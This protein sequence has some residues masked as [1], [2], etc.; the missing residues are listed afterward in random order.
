MCQGLLELMSDRMSSGADIF[1]FGVDFESGW[2]KQDASG[3]LVRYGHET[4]TG[5]H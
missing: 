5:Q 2:L 3:R 4:T 1:Q